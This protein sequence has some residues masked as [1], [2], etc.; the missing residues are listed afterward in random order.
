[1]EAVETISKNQELCD[2]FVKAFLS[3]DVDTFM[4]MIAEDCEWFIM[5]TGEKFRGTAKVQELADRSMAAR[6]HTKD[7]HMEFT[8]EFAGEE[9]F[10]VEYIHR[11]IVTDKWPSSTNK[12]APGTVLAVNICIVC[13]V[14]NHGQIDRANEY[15]DLGQ[16]TS[17]GV[18]RRL[19]S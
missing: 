11:A 8:N 12:P 9:G 7:T 2:K 19:Y 14:N 16:A 18:E 1:M 15:F 10:C 5:A 4:K 6:V 17:P 13:H 3:D